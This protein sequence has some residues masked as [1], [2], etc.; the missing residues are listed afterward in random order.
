VTAAEP[1]VSVVM[2]VRDGARHLAEALESVLAQV[3][4]PL[5]VVVAD[6]GSTDG[7]AAIAARAGPRV[8]V[9]SGP[10]GGAAAARNAGIA[11]SRGDVVGFL[12]HDDLWTTGSLARR[13]ATMAR[14]PAV[15]VVLGLTQRVREESGSRVPLGPPAP[16]WSLGAA[17]IARGAFE[18]VG[19][20]DATRRY[21]EDVDWFLRAR[22]AHVPARLHPELVQLYRRHETNATR[23]RA[24]DVR[25]FFGVLR[26]SI[27]RRRAADG[28][29]RALPDWPA[30]DAS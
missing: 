27:A 5:E 14:T 6:D 25:A 2:P 26:D 9:L 30:R 18:R 20:L 3:P 21:D 22:E 13:L 16:E 4:S 8:R 24:G 28:S 29:V 7:S 15:D 1:T 10:F 23:D 17:L 11:A 19:V 12:D